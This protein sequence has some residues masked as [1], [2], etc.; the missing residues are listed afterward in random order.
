MPKR[1][2]SKRRR[3]AAKG[4]A[5]GVREADAVGA[6]EQT[7]TLLTEVLQILNRAEGLEPVISESLR[8]IQ[9]A[10]GFDAV[11]L[12]LRKG[13]DYPYFQQSG[14]TDEFLQQENFLCALDGA[15]T[16][17]R[18]AVGRV[19][20][21]CTC[22]LV[23]SGRTE[24]GMPCFTASGSFWTNRSQDLLALPRED[25]PRANPRNHCIHAGYQSVGLFPVRCGPEIVGLLQLNDRRE[26]R[27][28]TERVQFYESL[29]QNIGLAL[30]RVS[31]EAALRRSERRY[32]SFIEVTSQFAW[33]TDAAGQVVEDIPALRAFTGQSYVQARG[34]GWADALHPDDV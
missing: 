16:V 23:V 6:Q 5:C 24:P 30:Q 3:T 2:S 17:V 18:D 31:A 9:R 25:D 32:R 15:G 33:V 21:E 19:R 12:R 29:A 10:T 8:A 11:G 22:G 7:Q 26:G 13:D 20:L 1:Q 28:T 4:R 14:F 27:F 34:A